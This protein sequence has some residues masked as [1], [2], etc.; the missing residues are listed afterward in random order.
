M[1]SIIEQLTDENLK[2][3]QKKWEERES[4]GRYRNPSLSFYTSMV[5]GFAY[6]LPYSMDI[7]QDE[8]VPA[9]FLNMEPLDV[10]DNQFFLW[11]DRRNYFNSMTHFG[12]TFKS[13]MLLQVCFIF[14]KMLLGEFPNEYKIKE[15]FYKE[16]GINRITDEKYNKSFFE[17]LKALPGY[18]IKVTMAQDN[19]TRRKMLEE[20]YQEMIN[21]IGARVGGFRETD[22]KGNIAREAE[23]KIILQPHFDIKLLV[24]S[25]SPN[26]YDGIPWVIEE[27]KNEQLRKYNERKAVNNTALEETLGDQ[28]LAEGVTKAG[29]LLLIIKGWLDKDTHIK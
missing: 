18:Y 12:D 1:S 7:M 10:D 27:I 3:Y 25:E 26:Y 4:S 11:K 24:Y 5:Y 22:A 19:Q 8:Y 9:D 29:N 20:C 17:I 21:K 15:R 23:A 13:G 6:H 14:Q 16:W 2:E 28:R